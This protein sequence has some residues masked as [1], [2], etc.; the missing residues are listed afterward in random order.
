MELLLARSTRACALRSTPL[1]APAQAPKA[2]T[3]RRAPPSPHRNP[4]LRS[5]LERPTELPTSFFQDGPLAVT[6]PKRPWKPRLLEHPRDRAWR[7]QITVGKPTVIPTKTSARDDRAVEAV[8]DLAFKSG[9]LADE[10]KGVLCPMSKLEDEPFDQDDNRRVLVGIKAATRSCGKDLFVS[11]AIGV[12]QVAKDKKLPEIV[13]GAS[14]LGGYATRGFRSDGHATFDARTREIFLF[15]DKSGRG[16]SWGGLDG[17]WVEGIPGLGGPGKPMLIK[18]R[19][20][21]DEA[22]TRPDER[23]GGTERPT[24][25]PGS[26]LTEESAREYMFEKGGTS[27]SVASYFESK[28]T[29][30][31]YPGLPL[32][33]ARPGTTTAFPLEHVKI[34][35]G[36]RA[37]GQ[38]PQTALSKMLDRRGTYSNPTGRKST[39]ERLVSEIVN[40]NPLMKAFGIECSSAMHGATAKRLE[41]PR[42]E[43]NQGGARAEIQRDGPRGLVAQGG[44]DFMSNLRQGFVRGADDFTFALCMVT[45]Q[46]RRDLEGQAESCLTQLVSTCVSKGIRMDSRLQYRCG[47]RALHVHEVQSPL[48]G[49]SWVDAFCDQAERALG[50][51]L[52]LAI[53]VIPGEKPT[54]GTGNMAGMSSHDGW[55]FNMNFCADQRGLRLVKIRQATL[56]KFRN[57]EQANMAQKINAKMGGLN[58]AASMPLPHGM[59]TVAVMGVD[60]YRPIAEVASPA[61]ATV[62]TLVEG[63]QQYVARFAEFRSGDEDAASNGMLLEPELACRLFE[64]SL[65][66]WSV[67]NN[68]AKLDLIVVLRNGVAA[69][70]LEAAKTRE[71]EEGL[72]RVLEKGHVKQMLGGKPKLSYNVVQKTGMH[73]WPESH[74]AKDSRTGNPLPGTVITDISSGEINDLCDRLSAFYLAAH[75]GVLGVPRLEQVIP[76]H[77]DIDR[78]EDEALQRLMLALHTGYAFCGK[79]VGSPVPLYYCAQVAERT[80]SYREGGVGTTGQ[81]PSPNARIINTM[82]W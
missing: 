62:C 21:R 8:V 1:V 79:V 23:D 38:P 40:N 49:G 24:A 30:L 12:T 67:R 33:R 3:R 64:D 10:K 4:T 63:A 71:L 54:S 48:D 9:Q 34:V 19:I 16:S 69:G 5:T 50:R 65:E 22:S 18:A 41:L 47:A 81:L 45:D 39:L 36:Q 17:M 76:L 51:P 37:K 31:E 2:D 70:S 80:S 59:N 26:V 58:Y 20:E 77:S 75:K 29:P 44:F 72:Q 66:A 60:V 6:D 57:S 82:Y 25:G 7:F 28:G 61:I 13:F 55:T 52:D 56:Q 53:C 32:I 11:A 35:A 43:L 15:G 42:L 68:G 78:A 74:D 73:A 14:L 46:P 27:I